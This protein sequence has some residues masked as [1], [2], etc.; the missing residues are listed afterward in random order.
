MSPSEKWYVCP[1]RAYQSS[2][3]FPEQDW[4]WINIIV[5][6][7]CQKTLVSKLE[8]KEWIQPGMMQHSEP[9]RKRRGD[10][11]VSCSSSKDQLSSPTTHSNKLL[12]TSEHTNTVSFPG[13]ALLNSGFWMVRS[14]GSILSCTGI[15]SFEA[16]HRSQG[17][18]KF[19][20]RRCLFNV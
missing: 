2:P 17:H 1:C 10:E 7:I 6:Q 20:G 19:S 18:Q 9:K 12:Q 5:T 4:G 14:C 13:L 16:L 3:K 15:R 11:I 8:A